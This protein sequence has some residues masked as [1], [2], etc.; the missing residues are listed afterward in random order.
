MENASQNTDPKEQKTDSSP[1]QDFEFPKRL[2][3]S[4][5]VDKETYYAY[6]VE[7]KPHY[8][9][10]R[11]GLLKDA[12]ALLA[13]KKFSTGDDDSNLDYLDLKLEYREYISES[14]K[15]KEN[16]KAENK[17][18]LK[19]IESRNTE[20]RRLKMELEKPLEKEAEEA[21][22]PKKEEKEGLF[23]PANEAQL[24]ILGIISNRR[25]LER[26]NRAKAGEQIQPESEGKILLNAFFIKGRLLNYDNEY[27][28]YITNKDLS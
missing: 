17:R 12:I 28:T 11:K 16:L 3:I 26:A 19:V 21:E 5:P 10:N 18:L 8:E 25:F 13:E 24:K 1:F 7:L 15:E 9:N 2:Q 20:I 23:I 27:E 6:H 14:E 4:S 22:K